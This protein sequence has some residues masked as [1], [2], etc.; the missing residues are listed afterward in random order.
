MRRKL[1][2]LVVSF[3]VII[4]LPVALFGLMLPVNDYRTQGISA[5]D[6]DGPLAVMLFVAPS[7]AIYAAG[8]IYYAV[9]LR[10]G[11][12]NPMTGILMLL[13]AVMMFA[14]A[15]KAWTAYGEKNRPEHLETCGEDW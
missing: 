2:V 11:R 7:L 3:I 10:G 5:V 14:A 6:C 12:R 8:A 1:T 13:C 15:G 9:L 4:F